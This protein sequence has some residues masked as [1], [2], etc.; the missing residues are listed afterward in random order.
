[1]TCEKGGKHVGDEADKMNWENDTE[2]N[3]MQTETS[4]WLTEG[5]YAIS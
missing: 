5:A 1:M 3:Q 4:K 2:Y